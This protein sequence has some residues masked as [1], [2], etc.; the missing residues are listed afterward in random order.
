MNMKTKRA[1]K[2]TK[3]AIIFSGNA[4]C[5]LS[6]LAAILLLSIIAFLTKNPLSV[7]DTYSPLA[8]AFGGALA[9]KIGKKALGEGK[10]FLFCPPI[11]LLTVLLLGILL[12]GGKISLSALLSEA[13]YLA[14][15]YFMF[16]VSGRKRKTRRARR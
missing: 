12:S 14:S 6:F 3:T 9:G 15:A 13:I 16:F 7:S 10:T 11:F 8:F 5:V 4:V 2:K 1:T